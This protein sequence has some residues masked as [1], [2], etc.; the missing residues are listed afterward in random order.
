MHKTVENMW[1]EYLDTLNQHE[2]ES[3]SKSKIPAW[4]FCDNKK[5]ADECVRLVLS[6]KKRATSPS[7]W[8]LQLTNEKIPEVGDLNLITN[9]D[10]IAQCIIQ[11]VSVTIVPFDEV[12]SEYPA[13][14]GE[15][16]GSLKYWRK[17]HQAY[18]ERVLEGSNYQFEKDM[19]VVFEQFE[20]V[21]SHA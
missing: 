5:D 17:V 2:L 20:V 6:G 3:I 11:T 14:E 4:H 1:F 7:I 21:Y 16:D 9:W 8:E 10:G 19:P 13:L 15:G 12:K 18:Y